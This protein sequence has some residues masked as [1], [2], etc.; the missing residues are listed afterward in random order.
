MFDTTFENPIHLIDEDGVAYTFKSFEDLVCNWP[1]VSHYSIGTRFRIIHDDDFIEVR[2]YI[3]RD[4]FGTIIDPRD[5]Q[6]HY[7]K[8]FPRR[9]WWY[10]NYPISGRKRKNGHY[11]RRPHTTQERRWAHAWDD[12]EDA[13]RVRG[14]RT[15]HMLPNT[16]DDVYRSDVDDRCWKRYR[17]HQ[18][19]D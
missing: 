8:L 4:S 10:P 5:V 6:T 2:T 19:K 18:W 3:L 7:W 1:W 16:Y 15:N 11:F 14:R 13:P 9:M 17:K 12:E